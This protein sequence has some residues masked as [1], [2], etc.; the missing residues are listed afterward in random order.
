[1]PNEVRFPEDWTMQKG[2]A[3][4]GGSIVTTGLSIASA[5]NVL[6]LLSWQL[7][8]AIID[9]RLAVALRVINR[10]M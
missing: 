3:V 6:G 8:A 7:W 9:P 5:V 4:V 2:F 10:L 1:M